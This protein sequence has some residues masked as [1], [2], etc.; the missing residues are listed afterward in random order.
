MKMEDLVADVSASNLLA[1]VPEFKARAEACHNPTIAL[2][3][4]LVSQAFGPKKACDILLYAVGY[5]S[6]VHGYKIEV[7]DYIGMFAAGS[8]DARLDKEH[9]NG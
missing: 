6:K 7:S 1:R 9:F 4:W 5:I 2:V 3:G 8:T